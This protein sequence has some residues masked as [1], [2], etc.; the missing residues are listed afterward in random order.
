VYERLGLPVE[1]CLELNE[2]SDYYTAFRNL[3]F[4]RIVP[5]VR[6]IGLWGPRVQKAYEDMGVLNYAATNVEDLM[7]ADEDLAERLDREKR[8]AAEEAARAAD[9]EAVIASG[10]A[11]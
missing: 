1:R 10:A 11:E 5:T 9:V 7:K 3:L 6:D 2:R 4:T 8:F